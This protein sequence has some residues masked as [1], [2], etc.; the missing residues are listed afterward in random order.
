VPDVVFIGTNYKGVF[1]G[2][3]EREQ[4]IRALQ[5]AKIDVGVVGNGWD[6]TWPCIG[7]C[8]VKQQHHVW[9]RAK[10]ALSIN[11]YNNL[12]RY[13]SDRQL[14]AMAS[15]TPVVCYAVPGIGLDFD[16]GKHCLCYTSPDELVGCVRRLLSDESYRRKV[17]QEGRSEVIRHHTWFSRVLEA[18]P[19][20]EAVR[21]EKHWAAEGVPTLRSI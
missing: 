20:I 7:V 11:N 12:V 15:G 21:E 2:T 8:K 19:V 6:N 17:G 14:I 10:V 5:A 4:A 9:K 1:P 16:H 13:Y 18:I 3:F